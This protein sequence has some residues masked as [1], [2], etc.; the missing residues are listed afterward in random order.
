M[1]KV[2]LGSA[3]LMLTHFAAKAQ[4]NKIE[5]TGNVGIGTT[6]PLQL[7]HIEAVTQPWVLIR[8]NTYTN[9]PSSL[10]IKGGLIF[11]QEFT[12][13]TAG[14]AFAIPPGYH[15]P[16]LLFGTKLNYQVPSTSATDWSPRMFIHP[17]GSIGVGTV[18]PGAHAHS[19][20]AYATY[21][22]TNKVLDF[23]DSTNFPVINMGRVI[24][25][26][27][28]KVGAIYFTNTLNQ[29]D[30]HKQIAGLWSTVATSANSP[31]LSGGK[32]VFMTKAVNSG[33]QNN[34]TYD[35]LGNLMIGTSTNTKN[36]RLAVNGTIGTTRVVV[37]TTGWAD[38][39]FADNYNLPSLQSLADFI[40]EHKH[41]PG[42]PSEKEVL[43]N[44]LD[45]GEFNKAHLE[46]T[47]QLT[48]YTLQLE[49][50][51]AA[52]EAAQAKKDEALQIQ[53]NK[54]KDLEN[55]LN[56]VLQQL[57]KSKQ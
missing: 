24:G 36:Y 4:T 3:F 33:V 53:S 6:S 1:K 32:L 12:D 44:G 50:K 34:M 56:Q 45:V 43:E 15:T 23:Q 57:E 10:T 20:S 49:K 46:K 55:K 2:L 22:A 19:N 18:T 7:L 42:I 26:N 14:I 9:N 47:E 51:V 35:E 38:Y 13:K 21:T 41:L 27:T 25:N 30:A 11:N 16:G 54:L 40:K 31:T 52:L 29:Q 8:S 48:L 37:T 5:T 28:G 17:A 39:V